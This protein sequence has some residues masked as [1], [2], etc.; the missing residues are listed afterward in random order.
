MSI[1]SNRFARLLTF[2]IAFMALGTTSELI[3]IGHYESAWQLLPIVLIGISLVVFTVI[4]IRQGQ[5]LGYI[6]NYLM[7]AC[8]F[9][10]IAGFYLHLSANMEFEAEMRPTLDV[11][12]VLIESFS[13]AIPALAPGSMIVFGTIGY[14]YKI[15]LFNKSKIQ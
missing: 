8:V 1:P 4:S 15:L 13:W 3:L 5:L 12:S 9:A 2:A 7:I 11:W 10:G 6:F 14:A